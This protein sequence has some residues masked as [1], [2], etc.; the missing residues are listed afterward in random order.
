MQSFPVG[1]PFRT[2]DEF[3]SFTKLVAKDSGCT[4]SPYEECMLQLP[5]KDV[6]AGAVQ[7]ETNK[8]IN[9]DSV[10][11]LFQPFTPTVGTSILTQQPIQSFVDGK[12]MDVPIIMGSVRQEGMIFVYEAF[13]KTLTRTVEDGLLVV[14]YGLK[15][16][17]KIL[18]QYPRNHSGGIVGKDMRNHT[19]P[20]VTDSLFKCPIRKVLLTLSAME[21][22][23]TRQNKVYNYHFDHVL[24]FGNKFWLPSAPIC[25]DTVCHGDDLPILFHTNL[26]SLQGTYTKEEQQLSLDMQGYWGSFAKQGA[27]GGSSLGV[28]WPAFESVKE[29]AVKL[30]T[31]E[32]GIVDHQYTTMC[33]FWDELGYEWILG[34]K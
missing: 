24:S 1:L 6:L 34:K 4:T 3:P 32:E 29:S 16:I 26:T 20:I 22:N 7:A 8:L 30:S 10:L 5:W 23:G 2:A 15:N 27:P 31:T 25:V 28:E 33:A 19:A 12:V 14:I 9:I 18:H 11:S 21:K 13:Q 17:E